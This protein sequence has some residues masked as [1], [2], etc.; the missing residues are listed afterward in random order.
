[1]L[2]LPSSTDDDPALFL[3]DARFLDLRT[4]LLSNS[5][6][7]ISRIVPSSALIVY[8]RPFEGTILYFY[9]TKQLETIRPCDKQ[10]T[11]PLLVLSLLLYL[12]KARRGES[13]VLPPGICWLSSSNRPYS[14]VQFLDSFRSATTALE[15]DLAAGAGALETEKAVNCQFHPPCP[16]RVAPRQITSQSHS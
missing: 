4:I 6:D 7:D 12:V 5:S 11:I 9:C 10:S 15:K 2:L 8:D 1:M 16:P 3:A 14:S 13:L